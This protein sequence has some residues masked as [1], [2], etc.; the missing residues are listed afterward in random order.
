MSKNVITGYI[1]YRY[2]CEQC[3]ME[4]DWIKKE[5][6]LDARDA[7]RVG[8]GF[9][10]EEL[11]RDYHSGNHNDLT[12]RSE[13]EKRK[14]DRLLLGM[15]G[16][17]RRNVLRGDYSEFEAGISCP[18]C[19]ARQSWLKPISIAST[20]LSVLATMIVSILVAV[21]LGG[22]ASSMGFSRALLILLI[23]GFIV[24]GILSF[25]KAILPY[26]SERTLARD[27]GENKVN[28]LPEIDWVVHSNS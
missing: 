25:R 17:I 27:K 5:L 18:F 20:V 22:V 1:L 2:T 12:A 6:S 19:A 13:Y 3:G 15:A 7:G 21:V 16:V 4:T 11:R 10:P 28:N 23:L 8:G 14:A 9:L 26:F 24:G